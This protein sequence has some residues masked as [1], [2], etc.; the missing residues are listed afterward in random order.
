MGL[1]APEKAQST[2]SYRTTP[3][4]VDKNVLL[5]SAENIRGDPAFKSLVTDPPTSEREFTNLWKLYFVTLIA[6]A[7]T[8][9]DFKGPGVERLMAV[10]EDNSLLPAK[11]TTLGSILRAAQAYVRKYT[12]PASIEGQMEIDPLT[13]APKF[14]GKLVFEEPTLENEKKNSFLSPNCSRSPIRRLEAP[15]AKFGS[16]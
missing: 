15:S 10:L 14:S 1:R 9:Y 16:Y 7:L 13:G 8:A 5:V 12:N 3:T 11:S 2:S 6:Q 4:S